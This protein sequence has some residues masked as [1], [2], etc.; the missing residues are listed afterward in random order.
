M[1][2]DDFEARNGKKRLKSGLNSWF[3]LLIR[4]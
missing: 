3:I 4:R 1:K 2:I